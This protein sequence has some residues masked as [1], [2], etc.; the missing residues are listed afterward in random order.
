MRTNPKQIK[1]PNVHHSSYHTGDVVEGG[2][3]G[4]PTQEKQKKEVVTGNPTSKGPNTT[5]MAQENKSDKLWETYV[6]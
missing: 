4:P 3:Q 6:L 2:H 5:V 1:C